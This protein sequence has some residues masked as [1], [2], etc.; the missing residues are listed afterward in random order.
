VKYR[1]VEGLPYPF[2]WTFRHPYDFSIDGAVETPDVVLEI[3]K[4]F[5][6]MIFYVS[7][8][9]FCFAFK[10]LS[11]SNIF[12]LVFSDNDQLQQ[13]QKA[14]DLLKNEIQRDILN[15]KKDKEE[16]MFLDF[17]SEYQRF[18]V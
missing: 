9:I 14:I 15:L 5:P 6:D 2:M 11:D 8:S 1:H 13:V 12:K 17:F 10:N 3:K 18:M 16:E 7:Y 4:L